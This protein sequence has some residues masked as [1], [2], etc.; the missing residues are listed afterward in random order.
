MPGSK[1]PI[2]SLEPK[3]SVFSQLPGCDPSQTY[4]SLLSKASETYQN[5]TQL[6]NRIGNHG[7]FPVVSQTNRNPIALPYSLCPQSP[8]Q[9][10]A[11]LIQFS[12]CQPLFLASRYDRCAVAMLRDYG[13]EVLGDSLR[14]EWWLGRGKGISTSSS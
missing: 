1:G 13:L 10:I 12:I 9:S 11:S 3:S 7:K 14:E 5:R 6:P 4:L 2:H 8:R